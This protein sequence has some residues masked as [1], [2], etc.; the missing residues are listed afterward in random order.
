MYYFVLFFGIFYYNFNYYVVNSAS[1]NLDPF[2]CI[3]V[4]NSVD[5]GKEVEVHCPDDYPIITGCAG[6]SDYRFMVDTY[7]E[8][9]SGDS[10]CVFRRGR[11]VSWAKVEVSAIC[12]NINA[13]PERTYVQ[14]D[15]SGDN[16]DDQA[17]IS[18]PS[19]ETMTDCGFVA[20]I[21]DNTNID[22]S[23]I[24]DGFNN[25]L[26]PNLPVLCVAQNGVG[27]GLFALPICIQPINSNTKFECIT[28]TSIKSGSGDDDI[29][30]AECPSNYKLVGCDGYTYWSNMDGTFIGTGLLKDKCFAQNGN[31][32]GGVW[33]VARCCQQYTYS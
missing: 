21:N 28:I 32:G 6:K 10:N 17:I 22:G 26:L 4:E 19:G 33:A 18:C 9:F 23:F 25:P 16:D 27:G 7:V 29:T 5:Y 15:R 13:K 20:D 30:F 8:P 14:S 31:N 3:V 2:D 12:C 1:W 24:F 11:D